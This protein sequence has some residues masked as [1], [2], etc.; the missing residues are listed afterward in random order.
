MGN[1]LGPLGPNLEEEANPNA[2]FGRD[3]ITRGIAAGN[4]GDRIGVYGESVSNAG[5]DGHSQSGDGVRGLSASGDGVYG[6]GRR[7]VVG[8]SDTYQGV[9]GKS[10]DNAGVVGESTHLHGIYGVCHNPNGAG[11]FATNDRGGFGVQAVSQDGTGLIAQGATGVIAQGD[12]GLLAKGGTVAARF[13]GDVEV[14]GDVRLVNADCAEDFDVLRP[15]QADAGTVMVLADEGALEP[16][17]RP[18]DRRVAGIVSGAGAYRPGIILDRVGPRAHPHRRPVALV[19]K[20]YCKAD[21]SSAPIEIGDLLTTS[22]LP[23]HAMKAADP[24]RAFGAVIGKALR[25][26]PD[27]QGLIPVLVALQ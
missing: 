19:G 22:P 25:P 21:A 20:V 8:E 3:A 27:G 11:V 1:P 2:I 7:G 5:V 24:A 17:T 12:T 23:G 10:R 14:T 9:F 26:L 13:E 4:N 6:S 18:Y 16:S 15:D